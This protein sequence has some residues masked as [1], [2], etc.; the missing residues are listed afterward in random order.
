MKLSPATL[1]RN[2]IGES[3]QRQAGLIAEDVQKV[4]PEV[5]AENHE[6]GLT[7]AYGNV[8]ALLVNGIKEL[9]VAW[10]RQSRKTDELQAE[11]R[12][13]KGGI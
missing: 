5:V 9:S 10:R 13:L 12:S 6:G 7:V 3:N 1:S 11:V 8:V 2:D 4:L